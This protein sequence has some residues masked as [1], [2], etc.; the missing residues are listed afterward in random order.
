[1]LYAALTKNPAHSEDAKGGHI[2]GYLPMIFMGIF[3]DAESASSH[4]TPVPIYSWT[5]ESESGYGPWAVLWFGRSGSWGLMGCWD[6]AEDAA[7]FEYQ[8][9]LTLTNRP[10]VEPVVVELIPP[11]YFG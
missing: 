11:D 3:P 1:M 7:N 8:D 9:E 10:G 6:T 4:G 2:D 5:D